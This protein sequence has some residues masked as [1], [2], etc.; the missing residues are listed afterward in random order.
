MTS[1]WHPLSGLLLETPRVFVSAGYLRRAL[2]GAGGEI[3]VYAGDG[4]WP[5]VAHGQC[6]EARGLHDSPPGLGEVVV[7]DADGVPDLARVIEVLP[8]AVRVQADADPAPPRRLPPAAVFGR[9]V[10]IP[11]RLPTADRLWSGL[12]RRWRRGWQNLR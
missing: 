10:S 9:A 2:R 4:M 6:V 8:A 7:I 11:R 5:A 3:L 12:A 1:L